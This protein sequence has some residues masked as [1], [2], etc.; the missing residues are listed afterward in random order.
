[1]SPWAVVGWFVI[2]YLMLR[3]IRYLLGARLYFMCAL[4]EV[5]SRPAASEEI[6]SQDLQLISIF[7]SDLAAG[8]YRHLGFGLVTPTITHYAMATA[9]SVFVNDEIP[10]YAIVQRTIA[11]EHGRL[12]NLEVVTDFAT[13]PALVTQNTGFRRAFLPPKVL[14]EAMLGAAASD[15]LQR[16]A[17]RIAEAAEKR[18]PVRR[19]TLPEILESHSARFADLRASFRQRR[20]V[21]PTADRL[22]DRFTLRGALT[23]AHHSMR[24]L[25]KPL[26]EAKRQSEAVTQYARDLRVHADFKAAKHI[27]ESPQRAPGVP[28]ALLAAITITALASFLAM[29]LFWNALIASVILGVIAFHEAG[30]MAAM[31][32]VGYRDIH[33]LFVPLLGALTIGRPARST[34]LQRVA[35]FLAGPLPG[36]WLGVLLLAVYRF[37]SPI[38]GLRV[39]ALAL[40]IINGLNLLPITPFDGGRALESLTRPNSL[41]RPAI[42]I[43]SIIGLVFTALRLGDPVLAVLALAWGLL[44]PRQVR[45]WRLCRSVAG[46]VGDPQDRDDVIRKALQCMSESRYSSWPSATRQVTARTLGSLFAQPAATASDRVWGVLAYVS[47]WVPLAAGAVLWSR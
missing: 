12:V 47:G 20:W 21:V 14:V 11:P 42:H 45:A 23:L 1:M 30:H 26:R 7:D 8:K 39:A 22:L 36:L 35:V 28:W 29:A 33:V 9:V 27:A 46:R 3:G 44:L 32:A 43:V 41:W 40:L 5:E 38:P 2:G 16:H 6:D 4:R 17:A 31:R 25:G 24:L 15:V 13:G 37:A 18:A 19:T 34:G 10:A